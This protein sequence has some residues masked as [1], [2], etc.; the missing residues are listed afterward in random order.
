MRGSHAQWPQG[1]QLPAWGSH[2][3]LAEASKQAY[4]YRN[5]ACKILLAFLRMKHL[6]RERL[7]SQ[8]QISGKLQR[9]RRKFFK[10]TS[11]AD[12]LELISNENPEVVFRSEIETSGMDLTSFNICLADEGCLKRAI[13]YGH[14][15][16]LDSSYRNKTKSKSPLTILAIRSEDGRGL[17]IAALVSNNAKTGQY[18]VF[19]RAFKAKVEEYARNWVTRDDCPEQARV[20]A[21]RGWVPVIAMIDKD[22]SERSA[23]Q[24]VF[25][26]TLV[27]LCSFHIFKAVDHW[28]STGRSLTEE[29][30]ATIISFLKQIQIS[31]DAAIFETKRNQFTN[32][33]MQCFPEDS[34]DIVRYFEEHWFCQEWR[35][36]WLDA[37]LLAHTIFRKDGYNTNNIVE[38][39]FKVFD[40]LFLN[41]TSNKRVD[42]LVTILMDNY[43]VYY[44]SGLLAK[45]Y[46]RPEVKKARESGERIWATLSDQ[47]LEEDDTMIVPSESHVGSSYKVNLTTKQCTC[48]GS[49]LVAVFCKHYYAALMFKKIGVNVKVE[50]PLPRSHSGR[51]SLIK[52]HT[53]R[54]GRP[55]K[56]RIPLNLR[57]ENFPTEFPKNEHSKDEPLQNEPVDIGTPEKTPNEVAKTDTKQVITESNEFLNDLCQGYLE[58]ASKHASRDPTFIRKLFLSFGSVDPVISAIKPVVPVSG[59]PLCSCCKTRIVRSEPDGHCGFHSV[60]FGLFGSTEY[61][62]L[63]RFL[64]LR[65]LFQNLELYE[66]YNFPTSELVIR[67]LC[68]K[69]IAT[70]QNWFIVDLFNPYLLA[71]ATGSSI[72]VFG[73]S[74]AEGTFFPFTKTH[75][76]NFVLLHWEGP[77]HLNAAVRSCSKQFLLPRPIWNA[78]VERLFDIKS[79]ESKHR[80]RPVITI[81][82]EIDLC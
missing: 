8:V 4:L 74:F 35:S 75:S 81:T 54:P 16:F 29:A 13:I 21:N 53:R 40:H 39:Q 3:L 11:Q 78:D 76:G 14:A 9:M 80:F 30:K 63:V 64:A 71:N 5:S 55:K 48:D 77:N 44:S 17:P 33:I 47:I 18:Q 31:T 56:K 6:I 28:L 27:R 20:I 46:Q 52:A 1:K 51:P 36:T 70:G 15:I 57:L 73:K 79:L 10:A 43:F 65:E 58:I 69:Q 22:L 25:P 42:V 62:F 7:P 66:K 59:T 68:A 12:S 38:A 23:I 60:S 19:L 2:R 72:V 61:H 41:G 50:F 45:R 34:A 32:A 26:S 24:A 37:P 49:F 67:L 82:A